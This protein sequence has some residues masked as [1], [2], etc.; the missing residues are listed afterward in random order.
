ME[1]PSNHQA[2]RTRAVTHTIRIQR[3]LQVMSDNDNL[4]GISPPYDD[5]E[6][7]YMEMPE[8]CRRTIGR[9]LEDLV[10]HPEALQRGDIVYFEGFIRNFGRFFVDRQDRQDRT[11]RTGQRWQL[12]REDDEYSMNEHGD[13]M[14]KIPSTFLVPDQFGPRHWGDDYHETVP[15]GRSFDNVTSDKMEIIIVVERKRTYRCV[16][17]PIAVRDNIYYVTDLLEITND[18]SKQQNSARLLDDLCGIEPIPRIGWITSHDSVVSIVNVDL[19]FILSTRD[20]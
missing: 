13:H 3:F 17:I 8:D 6:D 14:G 10:D 2:D 20:L 18:I 12:I 7:E 15:L 9:Y 16:A 1:V 4:Q 5:E 11:G 19:D